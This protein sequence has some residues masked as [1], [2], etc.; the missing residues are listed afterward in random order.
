MSPAPGRRPP[1]F[2]YAPHKAIVP[3]L[4]QLAGRRHVAARRLYYPSAAV[5]S[6]PH[7]RVQPYLLTLHNLLTLLWFVSLN[8]LLTLVSIC[9]N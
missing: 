1:I 2:A 4:L 9:Q 3:L 5:W 7:R 6:I 8:K